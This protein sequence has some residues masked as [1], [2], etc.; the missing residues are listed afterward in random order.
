MEVFEQ[1]YRENS[2]PVYSF[3]YKLCGDK[4]EAEELT[5]ET[6][7]RALKSFDKFRGDSTVF[8]WLIAIAKRTY[9]AYLKNKKRGLDQID[10]TEIVDTYCEGGESMEDKVMRDLVTQRVRELTKKLP[11][12]YRDVVMLRIYADMTFAEIGQTIG[13]T[14]N[15]AKVIYYRA[16]NMLKE[17]LK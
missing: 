8:T 3:L 5:Q 1:I 10:I 14:E 9:Y 6:F 13:I 12:K 17:K 15:S 16:K 4:S 2:A 7:F 11:E